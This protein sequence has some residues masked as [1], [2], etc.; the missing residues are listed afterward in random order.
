MKQKSVIPKNYYS[1]VT[2]SELH[3]KILKLNM[4][5]HVLEHIRFCIDP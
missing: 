1:D 2:H 3:R 4:M 5:W